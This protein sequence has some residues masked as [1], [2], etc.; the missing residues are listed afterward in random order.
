MADKSLS[1]IAK[2]L[3]QGFGRNPANR[4]LADTLTF[5]APVVKEFNPTYFIPRGINTLR[6]ADYGA[7]KSLIMRDY[8][9][10]ATP[11][12]DIGRGVGALGDV[13]MGGLDTS[14]L[15]MLAS[16]AK[17]G[18]KYA[19]RELGPVANRRMEQA[20]D[21][22][23]LRL[24]VVKPEGGQWSDSSRNLI[25]K[26]FKER[27]EARYEPEVANW[28]QTAGKKYV[29][30][31]MGS[32][33]DELRMLLDKEMSHLDTGKL[34]EMATELSQT[35]KDLIRAKRKSQGFPEEGMAESQAAK[36]FELM[37]DE[38]IN[39][40]PAY[41]YQQDARFTPDAPW[42]TKLDPDTPIYSKER[43]VSYLFDQAGF[44]EM[45]Q[46]LERAIKS[47][48][49]RAEQLNKVSVADAAKLAHDYRV[50]DEAAALS[51][52]PKLR[53]YPE[54]YSWQELT[55]ED[56]AVLDKILKREGE[57]MQNCIGGYCS[58]V[59]DDGTRL[60][61]LRDPA[62][63]P[64]VNIEVTPGQ[65]A[66]TQDFL[67]NIIPEE[68]I[69]AMSDAEL[70]SVFKEN[71]PELGKR[72]TPDSFNPKIRQI[73]GKQNEAP[74]EDYLPYVQDFVL[75]P[76]TSNPYSRVNDL[77]NTG[78]I[79]LNRL[80]EHGLFDLSSTGARGREI[81]AELNRI[82]PAEVDQFGGRTLSG[83]Y[84]VR[85]PTFDMM[86][87]VV[88]EMPGN[89]A[90][91]SSL[92]EYLR[93]IEPRPIEHG[94]SKYWNDVENAN[95]KRIVQEAAENPDHPA[96][97]AEGG[98]VE[99]P[100]DL[101]ALR[102]P[103]EGELRFFNNRP[104]VGAM[105]TDDGRV[106]VNPNSQFTNEERD[107]IIR[108]ER[109]RLFVKY[110]LVPEPTFALTKDQEQFLNSNDYNRATGKDR[111]ATIA[112]RLLT[113]DESA[114][115]STEEQ[116]DYARM[117]DSALKEK[118][119]AEG[120]AVD[121]DEAY[122]FRDFGLRQTGEPKEEGA[123]G[124]IRMPDGMTDMTEYSIN[125]DGKEMPS[126]IEGMHPADI[127]YIRETG[128]VP[129]DAVRTAI[130]NARKREAQGKNAFYNRKE[131]KGYAEGGAVK[132]PFAGMSMLDKVSLLARGAKKRYFDH[133]DAAS[134]H[135]AYPDQLAAALKD[136]YLVELGNSRQNRTPLDVAINYGGGYDFAANKAVPAQDVRDMAKAY[137]LFDYM[138]S[139]RDSAKADAIGDYYENMAGVEAG[140]A[141]RSRGRMP[142]SEIQRLS[143]EYGKRKATAAPA[144]TEGEYAEGGL[145]YNDY[146]EMFEFR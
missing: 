132:D 6:N 34:R 16:P 28:L 61:S 124:L 90:S 130:H 119:F 23:G 58:D 62:G 85:I 141:G 30:N 49:L 72:L 106:I 41:I 129:E 117:L 145:V 133:Y 68:E 143:A 70:M 138:T 65:R 91:P 26:T 114:Q 87:G 75:N 17:A 93:G 101:G 13:V 109:S 126:I 5:R 55:N 38:F 27:G 112:A 108:N 18:V 99:A 21:D 95:S 97:F 11:R 56:P 127:N 94:Y 3:Y 52:L 48:D 51:E 102:E 120:G 83:Q 139:I 46:A 107:A 36:R 116:L 42:S 47:G 44:P 9:K 78:L 67:K 53:E 134:K 103:Y 86:R 125:V 43:G 37:T 104:D 25:G 59:I 33:N 105:M 131:D 135:G 1:T 118:G 84:G 45:S 7:L 12:E 128:D 19:A 50:A 77:E 63:N 98:A 115:G 10:S 29:L 92:I 14:P 113:G 20:M 88:Q 74:I 35:E 142:E 140:L 8:M 89:Y 144:Y 15:T 57:V 122:E 121:V 24:N 96:N 2:E 64:H 111:R 40:N 82:Y 80:R 81:N 69:A 110:G 31:R 123:L 79:D 71:F 100:E 39:P 73:K 54:G 136:K 32:P 4:E 66:A 60:F 146:D 22:L 76:V 137:Q